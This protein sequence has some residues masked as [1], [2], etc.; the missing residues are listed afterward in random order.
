MLFRIELYVLSWVASVLIG[1]GIGW[2][3]EHTKLIAYE[4]RVNAEGIEAAKKSADTTK[5][6]EKAMKDYDTLYKTRLANLGTKY[7]GM[8]YSSS[9]SREVSTPSTTTA[10]SYGT[11]SNDVPHSNLIYDCQVTT[12]QLLTLQDWV[13]STDRP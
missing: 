4:S 1:I 2:N 9:S 12:V 10:V 13:N 6:N 11:P 5:R 8:H 7:S 3:Y